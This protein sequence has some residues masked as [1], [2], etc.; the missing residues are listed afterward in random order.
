MIGYGK[1]TSFTSLI[2]NGSFVF[3]SPPFGGLGAT[4]DDR[5]MLI[6][7]RKVDFLLGLIELFSLCVTAAAPQ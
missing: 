2:E 4:Y 7:K 1:K 6:G 3:L 5:L